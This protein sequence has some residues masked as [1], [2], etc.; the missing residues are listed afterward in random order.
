MKLALFS[1]PPL[2]RPMAS[3][4]HIRFGVDIETWKRL[5][6]ERGRTP[7]DSEQQQQQPDG[8]TFDCFGKC[9]SNCRNCATGKAKIAAITEN[10]DQHR[11]ATERIQED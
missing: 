2:Y 8:D 9:K 10:L 11:G 1:P 3:P 5:V 4:R 7:S 6:E